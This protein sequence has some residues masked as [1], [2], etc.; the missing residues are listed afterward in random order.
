VCVYVGSEEDCV[1]LFLPSLAQVFV[2]M[3]VCVHREEEDRE[4]SV[5]KRVLLSRCAV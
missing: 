5:Q 3:L 4:D 2:W 1:R